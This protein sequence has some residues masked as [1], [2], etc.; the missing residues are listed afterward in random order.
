MKYEFLMLTY[1]LCAA[2]GIV[3]I[4]FSFLPTN[5]VLETENAFCPI[6]KKY[7]PTGKTRI[8]RY[9]FGGLYL[10]IL[11]I[12]LDGI[13]RTLYAR[14]TG[15]LYTKIRQTFKPLKNEAR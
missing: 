4:I 11:V 3:L 7:R 9:Y 15:K 1:A 8:K 14:K 2:A 5:V 6:F 13:T 10:V 12:G